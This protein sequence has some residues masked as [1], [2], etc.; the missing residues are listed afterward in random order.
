MSKLVGKLRWYPCDPL[1]KVTQEDLAEI[2]RKCGVGISVDELKGKDFISEG[3]VLYEETM[4]SSLEEISQTV[5]TIL[6]DS[7]QA[8]RDCV[9]QLIDKYRAPR[10]PYSIW[11]SDERARD[12]IA[13]LADERDGWF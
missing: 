10:T 2:G 9:R 6:A 13:Q 12:I 11:G 7:E 8:F 5:V 1:V 3:E 4:N